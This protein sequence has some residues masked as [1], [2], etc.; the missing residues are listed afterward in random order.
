M[1]FSI[2]PTPNN[3]KVYFPENK[4]NIQTPKT[5]QSAENSEYYLVQCDEKSIFALP[6]VNIRWVAEAYK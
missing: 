3:R 6:S 1:E 5:I 4:T 2:P